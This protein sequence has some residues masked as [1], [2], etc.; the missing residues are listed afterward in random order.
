MKWIPEW[1]R[2]WRYF[3]V[4]ALVVAG[5]LPGVWATLPVMWRQALPVPVLA[6]AAG[7][8]AALGI[9]GRLTDQGPQS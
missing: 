7:V 1:K 3:S 6:T 5:A 9:I 2:A 8:T 4:H